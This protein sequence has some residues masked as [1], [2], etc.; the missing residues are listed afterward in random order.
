MI[1]CGGDST[2]GGHGGCGGHGR[3]IGYRRHGG[4]R[5]QII[6]RPCLPLVASSNHILSVG[7]NRKILNFEAYFEVFYQF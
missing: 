5:E 1:D 3:H 2:N 6:E 4:Y 7:E